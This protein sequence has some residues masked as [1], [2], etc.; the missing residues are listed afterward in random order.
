MFEKENN[1]GETEMNQGD[2]PNQRDWSKYSDWNKYKNDKL[3]F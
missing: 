2:Q 1:N 3:E